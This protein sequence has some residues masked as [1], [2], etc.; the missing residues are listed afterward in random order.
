MYKDILLSYF[1]MDIIITKKTI[2]IDRMNF[3]EVILLFGISNVLWPICSLSVNFLVFTNNHYYKSMTMSPS[4]QTL[5]SRVRQYDKFVKLETFTILQLM[6]SNV[7]TSRTNKNTFYL[8]PSRL[9]TTSLRYLVKQD[10][11]QLQ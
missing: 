7:N 11:M 3:W 5:Y 1:Y 10:I 4:D 8:D 2:D 9:M 6:P